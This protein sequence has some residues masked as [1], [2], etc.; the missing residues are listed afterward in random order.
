[1]TKQNCIEMYDTLYE[2]ITKLSLVRDFAQ[3][4]GNPGNILSKQ[5]PN[6]LSCL[7]SECITVLNEIGGFNEKVED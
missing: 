4:L 5:T 3:T 2:V 6:G 1:M 7:L